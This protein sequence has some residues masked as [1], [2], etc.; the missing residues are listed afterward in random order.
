[1]E[2][3]SLAETSTWAFSVVFAVLIAV[4]VLIE[5]VSHI[6]TRYLW[7]RRKKA[8]IEALQ[9]IKEELML[10]GFISLLLT[11]AEKPITKICVTA[12]VS[13]T[14]LPCSFTHETIDKGIKHGSE[15]ISSCEK[16]GMVSL[17]SEKGIKQLHIFIF[18]LA[19]FHVFF[20]LVTMSLGLAKMRRWKAWENETHTLEYQISYDPRRFRLTRQTSFGQRHLKFWSN[21]PLLLWP[22]AF[23]RQFFEGVS[24]AD[25]FT[26]RHGFITAHMKG[27]SSFD[28]HMYLARTL[29]EDFE[30]VVGISV[31][32]WIFSLAFIFF[33]AVVFYHY[34][35]LPFIPLGLVLVVGTKLQV[36]I[37]KMC[38]RSHQQSEVVG[39]ALLV[40]PDDKL[41]WFGHP[42]YLLY[43]IHFILFQNSFQL[44][45]LAWKTIEF[46][47]NSC[48][49]E[50][51]VSVVL[52]I[53]LG[54]AVQFISG[55][56]TL[57]LYALV[58]RVFS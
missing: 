5:R 32:L 8:L 53:V 18:V 28:F 39:G 29:D 30:A 43:L 11:V 27:G 6:A 10:L 2:G 56:V 1:M 34:F 24:K 26:L 19:V 20:C 13:E 25:Y 3:R 36:I 4:S 48:M 54:V 45:F 15:E 9:K 17:I 55:Y 42:Q 33:K 38:V 40:K 16:K 41:F 7:R 50:K 58:T 51:E 31:W 44:A 46:G 37:T 12:S 35:W 21:H 47:T 57:P 49:H 23:F 14:F 22:V 52:K